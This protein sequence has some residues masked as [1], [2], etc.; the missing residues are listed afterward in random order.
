MVTAIAR[1]RHRLPPADGRCYLMETA[2]F[3]CVDAGSAKI[4]PASATGKV[5]HEGSARLILVLCSCL[6][7]FLRRG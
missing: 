2:R 6:S 3:P 1:L 7:H 5:T 4:P